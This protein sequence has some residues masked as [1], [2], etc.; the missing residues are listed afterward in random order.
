MKI[1]TEAGRFADAL[2]LAALALGKNPNKI[3]ALGTVKV[4]AAGA[5]VSLTVNIFDHCLTI[6]IE[7]DVLEVGEAAAPAERLAR[8]IAGLPGRQ[9]VELALSDKGMLAVK[10]GS[11]RFRLPTCPLADLPPK[12]QID[13]ETGRIEID[14]EAALQLFSR[15]QFAICTEQTRYYLNGILLHHAGGNLVAVATDGHRLARVAVP[16]YGALSADQSLIVPAQSVKIIKRLLTRTET[17]EQITLRRSKTLFEIQRANFTFVSKLIDATYPNYQRVV[18]ATGSSNYVTVERKA[19]AAALERL[20]AI[21]D[22]SIKANPIVIIEFQSGGPLKVTLAR[23]PGA[24]DDPIEAECAGS[25]RV[26]FGLGYMAELAA[27]LTGE[28][29]H[30][31]IPEAAAALITDPDNDNLLV[32]QMQFRWSEQASEAAA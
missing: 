7:A 30:I 32:V 2:A 28:R 13:D 11:S 15:P 5:A 24:A 14:H 23:Q 25:A 22:L 3:P 19:L 4:V 21:V 8:L 9:L 12:P 26:A 17:D 1:S 6:T 10:C 18:P 20:A 29:L 27:E 16:A 31:E